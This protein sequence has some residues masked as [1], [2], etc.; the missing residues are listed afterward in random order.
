MPA[1]CAGGGVRRVDL[2]EECAERREEER[3]RGFST[4]GIDSSERGDA[5]GLCDLL[6]SDMGEKTG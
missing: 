2:T 3:E 4:T 5:G 6:S 1:F